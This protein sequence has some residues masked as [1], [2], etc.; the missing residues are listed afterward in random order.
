MVI[1]GYKTRGNGKDDLGGVTLFR[2]NG[3]EWDTLKIVLPDGYDIIEDGGKIHIHDDKGVRCSLCLGG[4]NG[5]VLFAISAKKKKALHMLEVNPNKGRTVRELR[6]EAG[7]TQGQ[8]A[9]ASGVKLRYIQRLE[10]GT[11]K[12]SGGSVEVG[13]AIA[14]ALGVE[15]QEIADAK[16]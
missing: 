8:L 4:K 1:T 5:S 11:S 12:I 14:K 15:I 16:K 6:I 3:Y 2:P 10:A 13:L 7:L 9:D